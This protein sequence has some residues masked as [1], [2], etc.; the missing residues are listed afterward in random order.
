MKSGALFRARWNLL[1]RLDPGAGSSAEI[2][3]STASGLAA[4]ASASAGAFSA[5][6]FLAIEAFG[7][8]PGACKVGGCTWSPNSFRHG[9]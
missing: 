8:G 9:K 7:R 6:V 2:G 4:P 1:V 3:I 5:L